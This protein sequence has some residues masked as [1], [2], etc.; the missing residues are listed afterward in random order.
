MSYPKGRKNCPA[1]N[2]LGFNCGII[3]HLKKSKTEEGT[4]HRVDKP[5]DE[6]SVSGPEIL[7][8][9]RCTEDR[10][11]PTSHSICGITNDQLNIRGI[12]FMR[13][14]VGPRKVRRLVYISDNTSWFYLSESALKD[15]GLI[16]QNLPN[17][18]SE[19][20][21]AHTDSEEESETGP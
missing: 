3:G 21:G 6:T 9:L 14:R 18:T 2:L 11:L 4:H 20:S 7:K 16:H 15:L 10:L 17:Q 12:F 19:I 5:V 13:I 8:V 1:I